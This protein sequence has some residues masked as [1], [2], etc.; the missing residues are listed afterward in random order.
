VS[1]GAH[2][3]P[4][5]VE[6]VL[7][8]GDNALV[9]GQRLA[10]WCG[11]GPV[12]EEDIALANIAL[13]LIGQARLLLAHAGRLEGRGRGEDELAFLRDVPQFR[14]AT[15]LE[16]PSSGVASTGAATGDYA[17]TI[18]RNLLFSAYQC[19][20]WHALSSSADTDLAAIAAK[21]LKEA[22]YHL[23]HAADW[24]IR[25][26]DGTAESHA[27]M[28]RGL[29]A[30][31]P[32]THELFEPDAVEDVVARHGI[33]VAGTSLRGAWLAAIR[34]VAAE[35][36]LAVPADSAFRTTGKLGRHSEHLGYLLA[37]M[38]SLHRRHPGATW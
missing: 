34:A 29:D 9:L 30:L 36:T 2:A 20:L 21:S 35:A 8:L 13:D 5:H 10:E 19:E 6:Y 1:A 15:L 22:R 28:Q 33:G 32:Y 24:A 3:S 37:E 38:Q 18:V 12:L 16:L 7:R 27:R 4:E 11:H 31:W 26:G 14:N 25:L 23:R 17:V